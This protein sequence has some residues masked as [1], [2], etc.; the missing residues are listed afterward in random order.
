[1]ASFSQNG[2][3]KGP[4]TQTS[5]TNC[6]AKKGITYFQKEIGYFQVGGSVGVV[7]VPVAP[8]C[9]VALNVHACKKPNHRFEKKQANSKTSTHLSFT[10]KE[11]NK[12]MNQ[13]SA[14]P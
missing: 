8:I 12:C 4:I 13:A 14:T 6:K 2:L 11:A 9:V 1:M 10:Y 3:L 7:L 5:M